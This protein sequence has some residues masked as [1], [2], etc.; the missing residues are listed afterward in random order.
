MTERSTL[1][2]DKIQELLEIDETGEVLKELIQLFLSNFAGKYQVL[3][4]S[5]DSSEIKKIAHELRSSCGN[6]G[7]DKLSD[8][9]KELEYLSA[10]INPGELIKKMG[11]EFQLVSLELKK[12]A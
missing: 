2:T 3:A 8:Y 6:V 4:L 12:K 5:Q 10:G 9:C 1:N 7:A 11:D